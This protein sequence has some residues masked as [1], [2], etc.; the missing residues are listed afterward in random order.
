[1]ILLR[2]LI[3][4]IFSHTLSVSLI[5]LFISFSSRSIQYLEE[6]VK[7]NLE[8]ETVLWLVLLRMPEFLEIIIPFSFFIAILLVVGR[9]YS[10]GEYVI[11]QQN[12]LSTLN[13]CKIV[14]LLGLFLGIIILSINQFFSP[15][16]DS[17]LSAIK[18][19]KTIYQKVDLVRPGYFTR[20]QENMTFHVSDKKDG[21]MENVFIRFL[22]E[23]NKETFILAKKGIL[24]ENKIK[25]IEGTSFSKEEESF[26]KLTFSEMGLNLLSHNSNIPLKEIEGKLN[27]IFLIFLIISGLIALLLSEVKPRES[28]Y[29]NLIPA[30]IIY[31]IYFGLF[32]FVKESNIFMAEFYV[33]IP[34]LFFLIYL[35]ITKRAWQR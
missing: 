15:L 33:H 24:Q 34:F 16:V 25:L 7:G 3:R 11:L 6:V 18:A 30:L 32:L 27:W 31:V 13:I 4:D 29:K 23:E 21:N 35:F 8:S 14:A 5:F 9:L 19:E 26:E 28:R 10:Q 1:M 17:R 22:N 2:Y 12:G 20:I